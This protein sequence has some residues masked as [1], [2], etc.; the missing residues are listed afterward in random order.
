MD[1]M[2]IIISIL[3][4][5]LIV[6]PLL[7]LSGLMMWGVGSFVIWAFKL[8]IVMTYW[9]GLAISLVLFALGRININIKK[10]NK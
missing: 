1:I 6:I 4:G 9:H 5:L 8:K 2:D 10:E 3:L 7:L